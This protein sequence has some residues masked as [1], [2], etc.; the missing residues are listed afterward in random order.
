MPIHD[1]TRV[2]ANIYHDFHNSWIAFLKTALNTGVLPR[3]YYA[4]SDQKVA[5]TEPDVLAAR[6]ASDADATG[7]GLAVATRP[8]VRLDSE[9]VPARRLRRPRRVTIRRQDDDRIVAIIEITSPANKDRRTS[10]RSFAEK[11]ASYLEAGVH[12]LLIDLL[13][14]TARDPFGLAGAVWEY[15]GRRRHQ[16]TAEEPLSLAAFRW[17][18]LGVEAEIEPTAVGRAL[19]SMPLYLTPTLSVGAP[20]EV[21]YMQAFRGVPEPYRV[22][23]EQPPAPSAV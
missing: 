5:T 11:V 15:F 6:S 4:L 20:L 13:P 23:L 8:R 14:P 7:A 2:R 17:T 19:I 16:P 12:T 3:G 1:W 9:P 21:T 10:V 22:V 18:E